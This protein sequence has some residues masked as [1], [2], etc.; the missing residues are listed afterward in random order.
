[1]GSREAGIRNLDV[2]MKRGRWR[3]PRPW[4]SQAESDVIKRLV[5]LWFNH[6]GPGRTRESIHSLARALGVSRSYIQK[7]VK[8]FERDPS[9]MQRED[10]RRGPA[11]LTQLARGQDE[12][13]RQRERGLLRTNARAN[14]SIRLKEM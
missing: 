14:S 5:W 13:R 10:R 8:M 9:E 12:T 6:R 3:R 1:V 2:A 11:N 4:R 7:L